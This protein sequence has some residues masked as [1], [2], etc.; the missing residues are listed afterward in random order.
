MVPQRMFCL[1]LQYSFHFPLPRSH[2]LNAHLCAFIKMTSPWNIKVNN[3]LQFFHWT[4]FLTR[5]FIGRS[6]TEE[7]L[8]FF[9]K[10]VTFFP[11][12]LFLPLK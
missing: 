6:I 2:F 4:H 5:L 8:Q 12:A 10:K 1:C 7:L 9:P 11:L 3:I